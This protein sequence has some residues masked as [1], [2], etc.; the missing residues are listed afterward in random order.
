[1]RLESLV[2]TG[3]LALYSSFNLVHCM[4]LQYKIV[5]VT[6][7]EQNCSILWCDQ[8]MQAVVID[9]GGDLP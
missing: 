8:T 4:A 6:A 5:P 9:P 1:M 7:F 2:K 3:K